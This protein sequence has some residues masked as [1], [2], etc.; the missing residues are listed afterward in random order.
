M[1]LDFESSNSERVDL[2]GWHGFQ[3]ATGATAMCWCSTESLPSACLFA[4]S[5]NGDLSLR[6][7]LI[8][9]DDTTDFYQAGGRRPDGTSFISGNASV[10]A[11]VGA[12]THVCGV[13]GYNTQSLICYVNGVNVG[14]QS[15]AGWTG[16]QTNSPSLAAAIGSP[17]AQTNT[18]YDGRLADV[19]GYTRALSA[20]EVAI[21][22]QSRGRDG[23]VDGLVNRWL[24]TEGYP[25]QSA[26]GAGSVRDV[27]EYGDHGTPLNTPTWDEFLVA[28][29]RRAA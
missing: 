12:L 1:S 17:P 13:Y 6:G 14:S 4:W 22:Y 5:A 3:N 7:I 23:I 25:G 10:G 15:P 11:S 9:I 26:S 16:A 18:F 8:Q 28:P 21:I 29:R 27:A 2:G 20:E 24:L 19:R